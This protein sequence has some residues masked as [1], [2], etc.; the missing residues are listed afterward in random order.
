VSYALDTNILARSIHK[1]HPMQQEARDA[2]KALLS[3]GEILNAQPPPAP[4][5]PKQ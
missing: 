1:N 5:Q 2:V 4:P 3:R